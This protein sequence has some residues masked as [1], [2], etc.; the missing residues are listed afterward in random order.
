MSIGVGLS[1]GMYRGGYVQGK[2]MSVIGY[3]CGLW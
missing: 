2:G 1:G 3:V